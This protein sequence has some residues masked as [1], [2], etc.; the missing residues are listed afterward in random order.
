MIKK[1]IRWAIHSQ[2]VVL[3]LALALLSFGLYSFNRVNVEA[4]P[5]PAPPIVEV[6]A[7]YPGASAEEVERQITIPLE[8][9]LSGMPGLKYMRS[10]SLFQLCS[11]RNQFQYDV[12]PLA[13]RQEVINR[14]Q[15]I[16]LP[17]GVVPQ[18]SPE[19]PTGE[20]LR[21]TL[22]NPKD[23]LGQPIYSLSDLKSLQDWTLERLFRRVPR[24]IDVVSFGGTVKRY[25]IQPDPR[26]MQRYGI[27]LSQLKNALA[28][29]NANVGGQYVFKGETV[30][31]VRSLGL[32]GQG[33]DPMDQAMAMEDPLAARDWL[34]A[35]ELR[36]VRE[37]R[38]IVLATVDNVPVRVDDVV[39]GGPLG[40]GDESSARG[41]VVSHQVRLGQVLL[42]QPR[43][44]HGKEVV[45]E[46]G[47]R[48]WDDD[49]DV[50]QCIV[51]LRKGEDSLPAL[52][53]CN[54]LIEELNHTPG[55]L[56]P[57][58]QIE[59]YYDRTDLIHVTTDT[60]RENLLLGM[61]LVTV[62]LLMFLSNVRSALIVAINVPL[63][64][65]F[66][67]SMLFLRDKSAN[68]LSIGAVDFGIIVDSSVIMV[69]N[70]FR[71]LSGGMHA[72]QPLSERII[73]ASGEIQ[74]SLFF[75]TAIMVC[76][77]LPLFTM[78][79]PEGKI[80][81]P[82]ADT[83][84]FALG[85][86]LLLAVTLSPVLCS[87]LLT[88]L[89]PQRDNF[90]VRWMNS[91][92][93]RELRWCLRH[94]W[95]TLL[96]FAGV[97][98]ATLAALPMLGREFMPE[99]EEGNLWIRGVFP[100]NSSLDATTHGVLIAREIMKAYPELQT[101][102][103]QVGRPDDGTDSSGFYNSE[104]FVTLKPESAWPVPAGRRRR[105]GKPELIEEMNGQLVR[106]LIGVDWNFSQNIRDNVMES[107]SGVKGENSVKI[108]GPDLSELEQN[109]DKV[110]KVMS[111]IEGVVDV[112]MF[113]IMG[114]SN[115]SFRINRDRCA[116]W[117]A[118]VSDVQDVL[119]SAVG[120]AAC[121]QMI[122][123][124]R[125]FDIT[126][127]FP[128]ALR[129]DDDAIARLP[130]DVGNNAVSSSPVPGLAPTL[131][132]GTASGPAT[133]GNKTNM[134]SL[135]GSAR[136]GA[137]N[138]LTRT[139]RVPL[140]ELAPKVD[141]QGQPDNEHGSY[142][143]PGASTIYREQGQRMIA[144]KFG[145][146]GRDLAGAVAEAQ[147]KISGL[148][149]PPYRLEWSG[150]F[151]EMEQAEGRLM[152]VVPL[153]FGMII[154]LLYM[155]FRSLTDVLL[156]LSNVVALFCGGIWALLLTQTNFSISA[157]VGFISIFGVAIMNGLLL[158]SFFHRLRLEGLPL[159][160]ALLRGSE[161]RLRPMMMTTLT[162]IFGLLPAALS[163]RIGA[164]TQRPLA[165][166]VI[167]GMIVALVLNRYL[168][169]VLYSVFR[170]A[171]PSG[172]SSALVD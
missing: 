32:V 93:L 7:Q 43:K 1:L 47:N 82:M 95:I 114:Q 2:L 54:A 83:Y 87:L 58:V 88:R 77:F 44:E 46:L 151:Q 152:L 163:T 50:V 97:V 79:G 70:I 20:I 112:G 121:S 142:V 85:G 29:S 81:G 132:T 161:H 108:I 153:A 96:V 126:L 105:R 117:G 168:T 129:A 48:R 165:I 166:V 14:L 113:R 135:V 137:L 146:R 52:R 55:R 101:I 9:A 51:L 154:V 28:S 90:M 40:R 56:L 33:D 12:D 144:I 169:P 15:F 89:K 25:E 26:R 69:E 72:K 4:Y 13:A 31:V 27:T 98:A 159:D 131:V 71:H 128:P 8:V 74:R 158:V 118:S 106:N 22:S 6:I 140:G 78:A 99:L 145:V 102:L 110:L 160:D 67:F 37:I 53:D 60:V 164:Q 139:P 167:G 34:R 133:I 19:S 23:R 10:Q 107:L 155:T 156:V 138:D 100:M 116:Q 134:P 59:P 57:G 136:G 130:V 120:G 124:E 76:A 91:S 84:A 148:V 125:S 3:L 123:G 64:L 141:A 109:A 172:E 147:K 68:L 94:R 42:S 18:I 21:Y 111:K 45:D 5:D 35:A 30:Q 150:E 24:I 39:E 65:L 36:R 73:A 61:A 38:Q 119:A 41:V 143:Q 104:F 16:Q 92:Y 122:E 149:E 66:A 17:A 62:V 127:R 49:N 103:V 63:A 171:A 11:V 115:L 157:A 75:S 80:F 170:R 162:A 86:A